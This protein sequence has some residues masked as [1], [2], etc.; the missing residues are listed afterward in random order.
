[1]KWTFEL[2]DYNNALT[3]TGERD[4]K[5]AF[6]YIEG[7]GAHTVIEA[8]RANSEVVFD[9]MAAIEGDFSEIRYEWQLWNYGATLGV[10]AYHPDGRRKA[11]SVETGMYLAP[12]ED[13]LKAH[14]PQIESMKRQLC[15]SFE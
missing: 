15:A 12:M 7:A 4:D 14:R 13:V 11:L 3:I 2:A 1:M 5:R 8:L 6:R 10:A 9:M